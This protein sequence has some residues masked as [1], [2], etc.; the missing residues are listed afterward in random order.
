[1]GR[2]VYVFKQKTAY[3][4]RISDWSSDVCSSDLVEGRQD[5]DPRLVVGGE[6]PPRRLE[7]VELRHADVHEHDRR[8]EARR[9]VDRLELG[10]ASCRERVCLYVSISDVVASLTK[11]QDPIAT[12]TP[13]YT[14]KA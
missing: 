14:P 13:A 8:V 4:V 6:D 11:N 10:R 7:P 12:P 1:M 2:S 9:L 5:Q 3:E